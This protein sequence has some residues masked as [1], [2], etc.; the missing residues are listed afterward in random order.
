MIDPRNNTL[1]V[2]RSRSDIMVLSENEVFEGFNLVPGWS[3]RIR[4]LFA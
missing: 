1:T 2:Y 4:E 3:L